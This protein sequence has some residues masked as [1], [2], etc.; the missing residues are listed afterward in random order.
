[1]TDWIRVNKEHPCE[2]CGKVDWDTY[3][4]D[5]MYACCMRVQS[6]KQLKN[7]GWLHKVG[8]APRI[9]KFEKPKPVPKISPAEWELKYENWE[10]EGLPELSELLGVSIKSLHRARAGNMGIAWTFPM[11]HWPSMV[12]V[13]VRYPSGK[14]ACIPG[15][16]NGLFVPTGITLEGPMLLPEGPSDTC[17]ALNLGFDAIGRFNCNGGSE[18]LQSFLSQYRRDVVVVADNDEPKKRPDGS[19]FYPG[20]EGAAKIAKAI[21]PFTRSVTVIKPPKHKDL[22]DWLH[23]GGTRSDVLSLIRNTRTTFFRK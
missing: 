1:M 23:A 8:D 3:T 11:W 22:R 19:V 14:Q 21:L 10:C 5:G 13:R 9:I 2:I 6:D 15:S 17:A 12:G 16:Q 18:L 7:G 20:Q 4:A